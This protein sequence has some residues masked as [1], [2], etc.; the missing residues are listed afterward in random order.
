MGAQS[1]AWNSEKK[2][3]FCNTVVSQTVEHIKIREHL[4]K[5]AEKLIAEHLFYTISIETNIR[6]PDT[7]FS[8]RK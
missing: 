2:Y 1:H 6:T 3:N 4:T 8:M 5:F 7:C